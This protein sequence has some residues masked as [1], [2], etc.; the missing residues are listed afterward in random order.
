VE[1]AQGS[2]TRAWYAKELP[3]RLGQVRR[4]LTCG[5]RAM[6]STHRLQVRFT[7]LVDGSAARPCEL[8]A[9]KS[10]RIKVASGK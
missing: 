2:E 3:K 9:A 6:R 10:L 8:H 4:R 1:F 7:E 5:G